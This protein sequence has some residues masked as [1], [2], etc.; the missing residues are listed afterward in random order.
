M[1]VKAFA[2]CLLGILAPGPAPAADQFGNWTVA[3]TSRVYCTA[4]TMA[5]S[6]D[7]QT[8]RFK[9]ERAPTPSGRVFVTTGPD[10]IPLEVGMRVE[11]D[12]HGLEED[13]GVFGTV[14]RIYE[15]NEMTFAGEAR[16]PLIQNLRAGESATI[17]VFFGGAD[18]AVSYEASLGGLTLALLEFDRRQGR[19][20]REDA[21][22]AWGGRPAQPTEMASLGTMG[23][24]V[25][26]D[27]DTTTFDPAELPAALL[28]LGAARGCDL[29]GAVP[30]FGSRRLGLSD[31]SAL[32][33]M[34][35]YVGDINIESVVAF[36][37]GTGLVNGVTFPPPSGEDAPRNNVI[38]PDWLADRGVLSVT[39]YY[40]PNV[41]CGRY[42]EFALD[43][44]TKSFSRVAV[45]EKPDCDGVQTLPSAYP[46]V[47][48]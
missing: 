24:A 45:R 34:A 5:R 13:Y 22:V 23:S 26:V 32:H 7:G 9:L 19:F 28:T 29:E 38:S 35:C 27:S 1:R 37:D 43:A 36:E 2:A 3:C 18:D 40:G 48:P 20:D 30:A 33:L 47:D 14:S 44:E 8:A 25:V 41:D 42:E 21:I 4:T 46:T 39:M 17:R 11:I 15:G 31:G 6:G 16:R 12:V 10:G